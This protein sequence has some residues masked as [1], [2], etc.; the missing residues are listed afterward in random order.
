M[1]AGMGA[2]FFLFALMLY[3]GVIALIFLVTY[4]VFKKAIRNG[5]LEAYREIQKMKNME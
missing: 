4:F 2:L 3:V 5:L 1:A